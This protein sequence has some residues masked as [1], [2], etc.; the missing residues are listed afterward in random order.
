M[1]NFQYRV[2][3]GCF[4]PIRWWLDPRSLMLLTSTLSPLTLYLVHPSV[5]FYLAIAN[6]VV[7]TSHVKRG[8]TGFLS[9]LLIYLIRLTFDVLYTRSDTELEVNVGCFDYPG[10]GWSPVS[11]GFYIGPFQCWSIMGL[12]PLAQ[13]QYWP[14]S[15]LGDYGP[16]PT[17][18]A[19]NKTIIFIGF[20]IGPFQ[21]WMIM[22]LGPSCR[23][24]LD[25]R[26]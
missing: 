20:Y 17:W 12:G 2:K 10:H 25:S 1:P 11:L 4:I 24:I 16:R 5:D 19:V 3:S 14:I 8:P 21:C 13:F 23:P 22:G 9:I 15:T 6:G 26:N 18:T 7:F